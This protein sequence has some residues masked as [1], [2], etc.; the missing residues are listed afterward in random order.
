MSPQ[1]SVIIPTHGRP[2]KLRNCLRSLAGQI[3]PQGVGFE[4]IIAIDG[5]EFADEYQRIDAPP[6]TSFL[7]LPRKGASGA[8][9]AAIKVARGDL[10]IFTND[11]TYPEPDWI[12]QHVR[13]QQLRTR[14][15]MVMGLTR[16]QT[17]RDPTVFDALLRDTSMIFFYHRMQSGETYGFRHF[18]TCNASIPRAMANEI[19]GF[20]EQLFPVFF[21]DLEFAYRVENAGHEGILYHAEAI[22]THDH[23]MTWEEYCHREKSLG[24][25]AACLARVNPDCFAV[26]FGSNDPAELTERY[27]A[28]LELDRG[29]HEGAEKEMAR[30]ACRPV[31][32]TGDWPRVCEALYRLHLPIKRRLFRTA[33]VEAWSAKNV[34]KLVSS[35]TS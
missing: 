3:L 13:A 19:G 27:A 20:E 7:K 1:V 9:N 8:R 22:N 11:D 25:M 12:A 6:N 2:N 31:T 4:T 24:T 17:W 23:R 32:E 16:W 5:M 33:F 30:W 26:V 14:P 10:L 29:D 35:A 21:E 34:L 28:W 15:G 18:W